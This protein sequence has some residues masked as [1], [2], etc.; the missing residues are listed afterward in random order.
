MTESKK[1]AAFMQA[2]SPDRRTVADVFADVG[3]DMIPVGGHDE[4]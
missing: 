4:Q 1:E 3:I 2:F